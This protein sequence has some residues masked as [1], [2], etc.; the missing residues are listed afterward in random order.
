V[1]ALTI[2]IELGWTR[3]PEPLGLGSGNA[4]RRRQHQLKALAGDGLSGNQLQELWLGPPS[5]NSS[6]FSSREEL[7]QA[8][9]THRDEVMRLWANNGRR[10]QAWWCF[11]AP[12]LGLQWPGRDCE[13]S[14]LYAVGALSDAECA[15][16][17]RFWRCE[18]DRNRKPAHL[19]W[20]DVPVSLRQQWQ[21]ECRRR[22]RR[23]APAAEVPPVQDAETGDA[24]I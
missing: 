21:A 16:L 23:S 3:R 11:D 14:Y 18:F 22:G 5:P 13:R 17:V 8:W 12:G 9:E 10:P 1:S 19:D 24:T 20:A 15:E 6:Y 4:A 7:E 2:A